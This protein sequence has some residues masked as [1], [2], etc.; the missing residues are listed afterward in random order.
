M[1]NTTL[2]ALCTGAAII[3][4]TLFINDLFDKIDILETNQA[5]LEQKYTTFTNQYAQDHALTNNNVL[6]PQRTS[7][8]QISDCPITPYGSKSIT[9]SRASQSELFQG[10][11]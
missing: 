3:I 2:G 7:E 1:K 11:Q 5:I 4:N 8:L 9:R 6:I 10:A